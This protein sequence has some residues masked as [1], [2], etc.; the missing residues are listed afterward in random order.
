MGEFEDI[1]FK[2]VHTGVGFYQDAP[3]SSSYYEEKDEDRLLSSCSADLFHGL[4]KS[5]PQFYEQLTE[6]LERPILDS[7]ENQKNRPAPAQRQTQVLEKKKLQ[8]KNEVHVLSDEKSP[9]NSIKLPPWKVL[10]VDFSFTCGLYLMGWTL[11]GAFF[12]AQAMPSLLLMCCGFGLFHQLY[13][14]ICRS[15]MG[16]TLGEERYNLT[17]KDGSA[18]RFTLRGL[19]IIFTGFISI[20]LLSA[21]SKRDLLKD[22]TQTQ[23]QY[24]I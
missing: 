24:N 2:A 8:K 9:L 14:I 19:M 3:K 5:S 22:Y 11:T 20:P 7:F 6:R 23:L 13:T 12:N 17:W 15:L 4:D 1:S 21:F 18:L 10:K 16:C